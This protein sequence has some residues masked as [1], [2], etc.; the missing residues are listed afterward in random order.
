MHSSNNYRS[1]EKGLGSSTIVTFKRWISLRP[2]RSALL[3]I[4]FVSSIII[5]SHPNAKHIL[6]KQLRSSQPT[7]PE[8]PAAPWKKNE[9]LHGNCQGNAL[10]VN[11]GPKSA[12]ECAT[13]CCDDPECITFQYRSDTG[14]Y[15]GT[16]VR[17]GLEKDG[18]PTW[19]NDSP[20]VI[21]RGQYLV[22]R[23][24]DENGK[25][26]VYS[27]AEKE[28]FRKKNCDLKTWTPDE[29][30]GQCFG[31]GGKREAASG[32]DEDCMKACCHDPNCGA[33]QWSK[34]SGCFYNKWMF[35]C[36]PGSSEAYVGKRKFQSSRTY[37]DGGG[38]PYQ[39]V[40]AA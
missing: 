31:L 13:T 16:D 29:R 11:E 14:C 15:Q 38:K 27:D 9:S 30:Q 33:W 21:W 1:K 19:C 18:T 4:I 17:L 23:V 20:P 39:Q 25:D 12:T 32:S 10:K 35:G 3:L 34:D 36:L 5:H 2:I 24:Q 6:S 8:C 37:T 26:I 7:V 28:Q 40:L 22:P